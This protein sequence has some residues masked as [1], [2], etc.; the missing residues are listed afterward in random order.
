MASECARIII[1][2]YLLAIT[3]IS[4]RRNRLKIRNHDVLHALQS[5]EIDFNS[6]T[7]PNDGPFFPF[8]SVRVFLFLF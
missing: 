3:S 6:D 2:F 1:V 5:E 4:S 8:P 7:A